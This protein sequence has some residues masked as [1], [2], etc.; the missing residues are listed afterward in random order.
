VAGRL[1]GV[2]TADLMAA[3]ETASTTCD[4]SQDR[5]E[6]ILLLCLAEWEITP[7]ALAYTQMAE[8]AAH[9][10]ICLLPHK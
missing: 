3:A 1:D 5:G 8:A 6:G 9:R 10:G 2:A 7:A 4:A